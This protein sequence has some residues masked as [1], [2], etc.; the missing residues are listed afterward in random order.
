MSRPILVLAGSGVTARTLVLGPFA[1]ALAATGPVLAAVQRPD[2]VAAAGPV[3]DG[4]ELVDYPDHRVHER[5]GRFVPG[6]ALFELEAAIR[7]TPAMDLR[8]RIDRTHRG[9]SE[10]LVRAAAAA[11]APLARATPLRRGAQQA[12]LRWA[13]RHP[14][15]R[16][17]E[18][19][20]RRWQPAAV[21]TSR[22][23]LG[24]C[25]PRTVDPD[26]GAHLA[27]AAL[28]IPHGTL[29][30]SW[31]NLTSK[32]SALP[33][34]LDRWWVW[35]AQQELE[36][37]AAHPWID[38]ATVEVVGSPYFDAHHDP[39]VV[40]ERAETA[41]RLGLDA[42]RPWIVIGAGN[43]RVLPTERQLVV[44]LLERLAAARPDVQV[45]VRPHPKDRPDGWDEVVATAPQ[46]AVL[47]T[48]DPEVPLDDG[49]LSSPSAY[50]A[51][52]APTLAHAAAV[53]CTG[54]TLLIDAAALDRPAIT[55]AFDAGPDERFPE[56]RAVAAHRAD[57]IRF[58]TDSGAVAVTRSLDEVVAAVGEAIDA[59]EARAAARARLVAAVAGPEP[60]H[61]GR[62]LAARVASLAG[63]AGSTTD[64]LAS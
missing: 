44:A 18:Q 55:L 21:L 22:L 46:P 52:L 38:P 10:R 35:S 29:V 42:E 56:G 50:F 62:R 31:D 14:V 12:Y 15:T 1:E 26:L 8:E 6:E 24:L 11:A 23:T 19:R 34:D 13:S 4:V 25:R 58:V 32:P 45:V 63:R 64:R 40:G 39:A 30:Q 2:L 48:A 49:G 16:D 54:S 20:L 3:A 9:R 28:G 33:A 27:A 41:R 47:Q 57:H 51:T 17:W 7:R 60:G 43:P 61:A 53:L 5:A 59:P 37:T 36:L